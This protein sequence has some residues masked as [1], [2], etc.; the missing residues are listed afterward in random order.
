M[1]SKT[2]LGLVLIA[3]CDRRTMPPEEDLRT[4]GTPPETQ[5]SAQPQDLSQNMSQ[6]L[7]VVEWDAELRSELETMISM[8]RAI[9]LAGDRPLLNCHGPA[10]NLGDEAVYTFRGAALREERSKVGGA[11]LDATYVGGLDVTKFPRDTRG[12]EGECDGATHVVR[13]IDIGAFELFSSSASQ[14]K[15]E[16]PLA[17]GGVVGGSKTSSSAA[18]SKSGD[19]SACAATNPPPSRCRAVI[20]LYL[21]PLAR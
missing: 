20:R 9:L 8:G 19:R 4:S 5:P 18:S 17:G 6:G 13:A 10:K 21:H 16:V 1:R 14:T 3:A 2:L 15:T 11:T 7:L 12:L